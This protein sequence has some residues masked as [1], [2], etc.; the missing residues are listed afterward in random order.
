MKMA[1]HFSKDECR[2]FEN[3]FKKQLKAKLEFK[4]HTFKYI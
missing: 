2:S 1:N 4:Q 3:V